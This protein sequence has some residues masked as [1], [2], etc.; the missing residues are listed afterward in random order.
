MVIVQFINTADPLARRLLFEPQLL[1]LLQDV[2][3]T[4]VEFDKYLSK[5]EVQTK[6]LMMMV[7]AAGPN[8]PKELPEVGKAKERKSAAGCLFFVSAEQQQ[9]IY[10]LVTKGAFRG[11]PGLLLRLAFAPACFSFEVQSRE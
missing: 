2:L 10:Q 9:E 6:K 11:I 4:W 7:G 3:R 5:Q 1:E 8:A